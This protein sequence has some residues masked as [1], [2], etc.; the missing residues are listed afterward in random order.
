VRIPVSHAFHSPLVADAAQALSPA[1]EREDFKPPQRL[2]ASTITGGFLDGADDL[3]DL[4]RAQMTSPVRLMSAVEAADVKVDLWIEVGPGHVLRGVVGKIVNTPV[5]SLDAGGDSLRDLL[6]TAAAAFVLGAPVRVQS[7]FDDRFT[8]PFNLDWQVKFLVNPC[9]LA[10]IPD[11]STHA[12]SIDESMRAGASSP[13]S[14]PTTP[15]GGEDAPARC[16]LNRFQNSVKIRE[17]CGSIAGSRVV[18]LSNGAVKSASL[19]SASRRMC[20]RMTCTHDRCAVFEK[21]VPWTFNLV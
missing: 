20:S 3:R 11:G 18:N 4:L 7:L 1:L 21:D 8:R 16:R 12:F 6:R 10:P 9:E 2:V 5:V 13:P 15:H 19:G 14:L 17:F